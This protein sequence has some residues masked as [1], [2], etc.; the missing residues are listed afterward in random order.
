MNWLQKVDEVIEKANQLQ[1]DPRRTNARCSRWPFPNLV[2]RHQLSRKATKIVKDV[3]HVQGKGTFDRIGYLPILD[4]ETSSSSAT[5]GGENY[6]T[7]ETLKEN[8]MKAL[9][10][11]NSCNIGV[12]G[13][14]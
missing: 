12:Y 4:G 13:L 14:G 7:R 6:E 11:N 9:A 3:V 8:I 10:H 1:N 2:L 5:R